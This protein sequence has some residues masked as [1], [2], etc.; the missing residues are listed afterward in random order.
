MAELDKEY[1][2][3]MNSIGATTAPE[4]PTPQPQTVEPPVQAPVSGSPLENYLTGV[5]DR[6]TSPEGTMSMLGNM[7]PVIGAAED[8]GY[9][10]SQLLTKENIQ[11]YGGLSGELAGSLAGTAAMAGK[12]P[13]MVALGAVGGTIIGR[14]AGEGAEVLA[15][16]EGVDVVDRLQNIAEAGAWALAGEGAGAIL[17]NGVKLIKKVR[18]GSK[19][20][21]EEG[22]QL[23]QMNEMLKSSRVKIVNGNVKV[24]GPDEAIPKGAQDVVLTPA[25]VTGSPVRRLM[26]KVGK[27]GFGGEVVDTMYSAQSE[28]MRQMFQQE[29]RSL[30]DRNPLAFGRALQ[31]SYDQVALELGAYIK[32]K[33]EALDNM[34]QQAQF[35]YTGL[36]TNLRDMFER[37]SKDFIANKDVPI[38]WKTVKKLETNLPPEQAKVL[39]TLLGRTGKV[40]FS[41]GF[42]DLQQ[43]TKL[44]RELRNTQGKREYA[45]DIDRIIDVYRRT[46]DTQAEK[47]AKAGGSEG[48]S[49]YTE[50]QNLDGVYEKVI[51][52][53][54][55]DFA[56]EILKTDPESIAKALYAEGNVTPITNLYK[57][58]RSLKQFSKELEGTGV[59]AKEILTDFKA[60]YADAFFEDLTTSTG[61]DAV[62]LAQQML[63]KLG[64]GSAFGKSETMNTFKAVLNPAERKRMTE[65]LKN[66]AKMEQISAGNFSLAVRGQQ[67]AGLRKFGKGIEGTLGATGVATGVAMASLPASII[68]GFAFFMGP[69]Y[70]AKAAVHG[71][72]TDD[73]L[74]QVNGLA[75]KAA[76]GKFDVARDGALLMTLVGS[77]ATRQSDI[78]EE[79]QGDPELPVEHQ[80]FL[81]SIELDSP[82]FGFPVVK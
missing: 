71:K 8:L 38:T 17:M 57:D 59:N 19:L 51:K 64:E 74:K 50:L 34:A 33:Y 69:R 1:L 27:A 29:I 40:S 12:P 42:D 70:L 6:L 62:D 20:T 54:R 44:A 21:P 60:G 10:P 32:P 67:T 16:E 18:A 37:G 28:A 76:A 81:K 47:V 55:G 45:T 80:M 66:A 43:L 15:G 41:T 26:E 48:R 7:N 14:S 35:N 30:G 31:N 2:D 9:G 25:Q 5:T 78:P 53:T 52:T 49:L 72:I 22:Q 73:I 58:A 39:K 3:F 82:E 11:Q 65:L 36:R 23:M 13:W 68:S 56:K 46:L 24:F 79:L 61:D 4:E 77:S 63:S 75:H